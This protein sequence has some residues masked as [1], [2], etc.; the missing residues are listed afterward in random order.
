[1]AYY[2]L[3][4]YGIQEVQRIPAA[5]VDDWREISMGLRT[6]RSKNALVISAC[7]AEIMGIGRDEAF[8]RLFTK[9]R[10]PVTSRSTKKHEERSAAETRVKTQSTST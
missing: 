10:A 9:V 1:M 6:V 3:N 7:Y 4:N 5:P 8:A 2:Q